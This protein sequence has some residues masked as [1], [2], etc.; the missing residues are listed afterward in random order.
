[1]DN[2][3][4]IE[5]LAEK[6]G[7]DKEKVSKTIEDMCEIIAETIM[8]EDCVVIPAFGCFEPKKKMERVVVHPSS[9]KKL[10]VPPRL[11][12]G[13]KPSSLLRSNVRNS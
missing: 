12:I 8:E 5:S 11:S 4:F 3:S 2:K 7:L 10:M 1:M 6:S 13:F 9:G